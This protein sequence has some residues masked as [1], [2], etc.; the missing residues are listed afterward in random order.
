ME[1]GTNPR[2]SRLARAAVRIAELAPV[3]LHE[4]VDFTVGSRGLARRA[5]TGDESFTDAVQNRGTC[6]TG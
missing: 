4:A 5:W 2:N 1:K 6:V 3:S